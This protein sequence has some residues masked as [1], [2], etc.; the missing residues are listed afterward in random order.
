MQ[1]EKA[2]GPWER[3]RLEGLVSADTAVT[4]VGCPRLSVS[5]EQVTTAT[6]S[7]LCQQGGTLFPVKCME[8]QV[9]FSVRFSR[10]LTVPFLCS[11]Q[12]CCHLNEGFF[13]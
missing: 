6:G 13:G 2:G 9:V 1:S 4:V 5:S 11:K 7:C 10:S 3:A 12:K 8:T